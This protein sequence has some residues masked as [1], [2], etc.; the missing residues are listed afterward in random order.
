MILRVLHP[1]I[2]FLETGAY[3]FV[4]YQI[5]RNCALGLLAAG[6]LDAARKEIQTCQQF[7]PGSVDLGIHLVPELDRL[8]H[9]KDADELFA[10]LWKIREKAS[11]ESLKNSTAHNDLAWLAAR[12]HR[13]LDKGLEHAR[14][15][16]ELEPSNAGHLDTL[17]E[18]TFQRGDKDKAQELMKKCISLDPGN[19]YFQSQLKHFAAGDPAAPLPETSE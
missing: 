15:A 5:H 18:V 3:I 8:G 1:N 10:A 17:A 12:C 4:P 16:V 13:Q 7:L 2:N 14:K 11:E 19:S 9:K 6:N